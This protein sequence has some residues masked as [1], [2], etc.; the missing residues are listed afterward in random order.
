MGKMIERGLVR[1]SAVGGGL[2][3]RG[4]EIEFVL[5]IEVIEQTEN[6]SKIKINEITGVR[7]SLHKQIREGFPVW[8]PTSEIIP[9]VRPQSRP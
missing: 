5:E 9:L 6:M 2:L 3:N 1:G 4:E 7:K 8:I